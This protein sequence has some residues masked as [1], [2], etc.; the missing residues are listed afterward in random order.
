MILERLSVRRAAS[1]LGYNESQL[2]KW[3]GYDTSRRILNAKEN[4]RSIGTYCVFKYK[5]QA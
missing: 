2:R 3:K 4:T 5:L 1:I